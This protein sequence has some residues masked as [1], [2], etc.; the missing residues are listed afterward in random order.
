M[1]WIIYQKNYQKKT[2][3]TINLSKILKIKATI[4]ISNLIEHY[5]CYNVIFLQCV[6]QNS[7]NIKCFIS[8]HKI[9]ILTTWEIIAMLSVQ[10][11]P[12]T[13]QTYVPKIHVIYLKETRIVRKENGHAYSINYRNSILL[14]LC[15]N[16]LDVYS[17]LKITVK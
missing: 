14:L 9:S 17:N 10:Y 12:D 5:Q 3:V 11:L 7:R 4:P 1:I 15:Y 16:R 8:V 6:K 2:Q 13:F